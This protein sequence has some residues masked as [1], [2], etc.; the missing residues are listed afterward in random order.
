MTQT[1]DLRIVIP[2]LFLLSETGVYA[3][4]IHKKNTV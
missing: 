2:F 4:F 3:F 1:V